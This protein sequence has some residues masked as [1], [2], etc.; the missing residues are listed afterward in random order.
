MAR[1]LGLVMVAVLLSSSVADAENRITITSVSAGPNCGQLT[2]KV[3]AEID[4]N[5]KGGAGKMC[6]WI[7]GEEVHFFSLEETDRDSCFP[8]SWITYECTMSL[9]PATYNILAQS[10]FV[11]C[12]ESELRFTAPITGSPK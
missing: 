8:S 12:C 4:A 5:W 6:V 2:V 10:V 7:S 1:T 3:K 11:G 9:A